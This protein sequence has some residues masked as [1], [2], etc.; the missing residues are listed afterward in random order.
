MGYEIEK[1]EKLYAIERYF[2][3]VV[4]ERVGGKVA[5]KLKVQAR[6]INPKRVE[7]RVPRRFL[8]ICIGREGDTVQGAQRE[9][10]VKIDIKPD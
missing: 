4:G 9:F 8:A 7:V 5:G 2:R 1:K 6:W 3:L 10:K